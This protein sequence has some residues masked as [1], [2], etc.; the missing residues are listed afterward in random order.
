MKTTLLTAVAMCALVSFDVWADPQD[1]SVP[2]ASVG[3]GG[4]DMNNEE[5]DKEGLPCLDSKSCDARTACVN[6]RCVPTKVRDIGG[7]ST[8]PGV[9]LAMLAG[10]AVIA[11]RRRG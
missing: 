6:G 11:L 8:S 7:C 4:A 10:L 3:Q 1:A 2:D 9:G 5:N